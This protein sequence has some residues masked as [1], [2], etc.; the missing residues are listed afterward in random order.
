MLLLEAQGTRARRRTMTAED[1]CCC[2]ELNT[3]SNDEREL[4]SIALVSL[5]AEGVG[6][7]GRGEERGNGESSMYGRDSAL[8]QHEQIEDLTPRS[9]SRFYH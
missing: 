7:K 8:I 9:S 5:A 1:A 4:Q 3:R 2:L 6:T